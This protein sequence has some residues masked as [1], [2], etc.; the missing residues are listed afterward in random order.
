MA[1]I[2]RPP[3][4]RSFS[5]KK[6]MCLCAYSGR[7]IGKH[8][9]S[10]RLTGLDHK[11]VPVPVE[12][13][14]ASRL[15]CEFCSNWT[16]GQQ[17]FPSATK[18]KKLRRREK[19]GLSVG[20]S[21]PCITRTRMSILCWSCDFRKGLRNAWALVVFEGWVYRPSGEEAILLYTQVKR[22]RP[23]SNKKD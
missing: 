3:L 8:R 7:Y 14:S 17:C 20:T 23:T 9:D 19:K 4:V 12:R 18:K 5:T 6:T 13:C 2:Y 1:T 15:H 11:E 16:A 10:F 22:W 21:M